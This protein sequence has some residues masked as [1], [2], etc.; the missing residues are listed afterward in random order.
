MLKVLILSYLK[1][2]DNVIILKGYLFDPENPFYGNNED[3]N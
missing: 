3:W 1:T 2:V